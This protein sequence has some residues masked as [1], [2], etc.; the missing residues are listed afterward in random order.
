MLDCCYA[1]E[2]ADDS[3]DWGDHTAV[4]ASSR[5]W[6]RATGATS[7]LTAA[8]TAAWRAGPATAGELLD[9]LGGVDAHTNRNYARALVLPRPAGVPD[10]PVAAPK[11]AVRLTV[12]HAG[13]LHIALSSGV[14]S[15][16]SA[17][18]AASLEGRRELVTNL[19]GMVDAVIAYAPR[20]GELMNQVT[21]AL[22]ALGTDLLGSTLTTQVRGVLD[23]HIQPWTELRLGSASTRRGPTGT[24][25]NGCSGRA[26]RCA[27]TTTAR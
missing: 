6:V 27:A 8:V 10:E 5:Q 22:R 19:L 15:V 21:A 7:E 16:P 24:G 25:G 11:E 3:L 9:A 23:A 26:S 18:L 17:P 1:G 12:D 4:L 13:E 14:V 2:A 20:D